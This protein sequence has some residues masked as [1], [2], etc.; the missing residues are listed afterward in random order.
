MV[1]KVSDALV[2]IFIICVFRC[3]I[4]N[5]NLRWCWYNVFIIDG[6]WCRCCIVA[7]LTYAFT[8]DWG[9][10]ESKFLATTSDVATIIRFA[11]AW[12]HVEQTVG[13]N[14]HICFYWFKAS[15]LWSPSP[16]CWRQSI[17]HPLLNCK[18]STVGM[19]LCCSTGWGKLSSWNDELR[20]L[21]PIALLYATWRYSSR[22]W[23]LLAPYS[24]RMK[25]SPAFFAS[26][27][28]LSALV[29]VSNW[30]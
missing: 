26:L 27:W 12:N 14:R 21:R 5:T 23:K 29:N 17:S 24:L 2:F 6:W 15:V 25:L 8:A 4:F 3:S 16:F 11:P 19:L 1:L 9:A 30:S 10:K 13:C 22:D 7:S 18:V 20:E 28:V